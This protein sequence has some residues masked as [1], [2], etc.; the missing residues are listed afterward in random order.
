MSHSSKF[1]RTILLC[2]CLLILNQTSTL[3]AEQGAWGGN[4][5][6]W[7]GGNRQWEGDFDGPGYH[8]SPCNCHS[9]YQSHDHCHHSY[10][11]CHHCGHYHHSPA[12]P[13]YYDESIPGAGLYI[14][15]QNRCR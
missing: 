9:R 11:Q 8:Q 14:N 13:Y 6:W 3:S 1:L 5:G 2:T 4:G 7:G 12:T 10:D 15:L